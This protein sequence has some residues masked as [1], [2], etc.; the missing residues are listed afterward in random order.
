MNME[1]RQTDTPH[2]YSRWERF[3]NWLYYHKLWLIVAAVLLWI[4]GTMV[5]NLLGIGKTEPDYRFAYVG[6]APLPE[7]CVAALE[8][9]LAT[10][11]EDLNGDGSVVVTL[12][13]HVTGSGAD[14]ETALAYGYAASVTL[15]A[16]LTDEESCFFL[17]EDPE[18][19]QLDYQILADADGEMPESG[20]FSVEGKTWRWED[21]PVLAGLELGSGAEGAY[22]SLLASLYVGMRCYYQPE[23]VPAWEQYRSYWNTMIAGA[24]S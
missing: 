19:F 24:I 9:Q 12:Q 1:A 4:G 3:Q 16:D 13:Q 15:M 18:A 14:E 21:C 8:T 6:S 20:D 7:D 23:R 17:L 5:W 2:S 22:Q 10:L 11:G